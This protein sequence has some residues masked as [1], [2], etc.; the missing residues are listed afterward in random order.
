M[1]HLLALLTDI[2]GCFGTA[3]LPG[4][5]GVVSLWFFINPCHHPRLQLVI[6]LR[7]V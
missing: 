5:T 1:M 4:N 2:Q 7:V 3:E 6:A